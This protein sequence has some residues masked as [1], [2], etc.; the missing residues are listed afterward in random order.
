MRTSQ[1]KGV[2]NEAI[3]LQWPVWTTLW[4][5]GALLSVK[6]CYFVQKPSWKSHKIMN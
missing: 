4:D 6:C 5:F 3:V 2:T 1:E